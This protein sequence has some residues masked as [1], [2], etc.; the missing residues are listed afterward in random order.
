M[1]AIAN[2][3]ELA[4]EDVTLSSAGGSPF[5]ISYGLTFLLTATFSL[6]LS[7]RVVALIAM[8]QGGVSLPLAFW[9]EHRLGKKRMSSDNPLKPLSVQLAISQA[10]GLPTL[11][12]VYSLEPKLIPLAL[13]SLGG[14]HFMP[15]AWV[16]NSKIYIY[17]AVAVSIGAYVI[18][19]VLATN[20][21]EAILLWVAMVYFVA[22]VPIYKRF[23]AMMALTLL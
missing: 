6:F 19:S 7:A 4:R 15:Y 21:F 13:A 20:D 16:H 22:A 2:D 9:L 8:F 23:S 3:L 5:L 17:L 14:V 1:K 12:A 18:Q 10:L 11:I